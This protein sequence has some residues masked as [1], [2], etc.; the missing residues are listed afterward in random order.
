MFKAF[1]E[2]VLQIIVLLPGRVLGSRSRVVSIYRWSPLCP[3][4]GLLNSVHV[5]GEVTGT[6]EDVFIQKPWKEFLPI[7]TVVT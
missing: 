1:R 2:A 3:S 5:D 7:R 6:N 4:E